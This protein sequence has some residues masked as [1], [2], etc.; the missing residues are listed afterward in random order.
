[1]VGPG[2]AIKPVRK[3]PIDLQKGEELEAV[4]CF[5]RLTYWNHDTRPSGLDEM[6]QLMEWAAVSGI[7]H[8]ARPDM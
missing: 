7:M 1:M 6:P 2:Y 8:G 4:K 5:S 3:G